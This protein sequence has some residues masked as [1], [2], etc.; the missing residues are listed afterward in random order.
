MGRYASGAC[1]F[2]KR[3]LAK[4]YAAAANSWPCKSVVCRI[5]MQTV[6]GLSAAAALARVG[7]APTNPAPPTSFKKIP[8]RPESGRIKHHCHHRVERHFN[9]EPAMISIKMVV[10]LILTGGFLQ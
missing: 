7:S 9:L 3:N 2:F 8:S 6:L 10:R 5:E 1:G 4:V